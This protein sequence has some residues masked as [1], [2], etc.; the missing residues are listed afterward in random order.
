MLILTSVVPLFTFGLF[1]LSSAEGFTQCYYPDG[2]IPTDYVWE[3]CTGANYSSCCV[4]SEGDVCQADGLCYYPAENLAYRGTCT[5]RTWNDPSCN[6]NICVTGFETTWTWALQCDGPGG[7]DT[8]VCGTVD[9]NGYHESPLNLTCPSNEAAQ[10]TFMT[11]TPTT[12]AGRYTPPPSVDTK[13]YSV[14]TD[15][16]T[17][18][19]TANAQT[20]TLTSTYAST[21]TSKIAAAAASATETNTGIP[22]PIASGSTASDSKGA[23]TL[24]IGVLVGI[25]IAVIA[26]L[27]VGL[28][29][30]V[31]LRNKY[32]KKK[33]EQIRLNTASPPPPNG[34][35]GRDQVHPYEAPANE[36]NDAE[37]L[38]RQYGY[39][40]PKVDTYEIDNHG[41]YGRG[42]EKTAAFGAGRVGVAEMRGQEGEVMRSPAPE[43]SVA[44][45]PVEL[46]ASSSVHAPSRGE[47]RDYT[48]YG[49]Y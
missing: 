7:S 25:I 39:M 10:T 37:K 15:Q 2:S 4:P 12:T 1:Q 29:I 13:I 11:T 45:M 38:K 43:Y 9:A 27:T 48:G 44:V 22:I 35:V 34:P 16:Y 26:L 32:R 5:D 42:G 8:F 40:G 30:A 18:T 46:D 31:I 20:T 24:S 49:R 21:F 6:A 23:V 36:V 47:N 17:V 19:I 14:F 41:V 3:P 28:I 33:E